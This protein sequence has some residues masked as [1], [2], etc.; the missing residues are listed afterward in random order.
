MILDRQLLL[1][2]AQPITATAVSTNSI[3]LASARDIGIGDSLELFVKVIT[4][5][6]GGTSVQFAYITSAN[7][8]LSSANVVVQTPP[9][10][11]ASLLA[12]SEWLR[13]R[14]PVLSDAASRQRYLGVSYA[15][16]GNFTSGTVTA[17]LVLDREGLVSYPSGL[18]AGGF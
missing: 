16:A 13:I 9:I 8:D 15:V 3:D 18:N 6:A 7:A 14:L 2:N 1:S 17:G 11:A 4:P 10:P 5:L 12:G